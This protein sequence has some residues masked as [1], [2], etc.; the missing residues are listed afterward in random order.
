MNK[1]LLI[2][3]KELLRVFGDRKLVMGLFVTPMLTMVVVY[4]FLGIF[5]GGMATKTAE[6]QCNV[7]V[8]G[9]APAALTARLEQNECTLTTAAPEEYDALTQ[10]IREEDKVDMLLVFPDGFEEAI[11]RG[12][13][14][15]IEVVCDPSI[16]GSKKA[17]D[18]FTAASGEYRDELLA[19]RL[20]G[21]EKLQLFVPVLNSLEN[22]EETAGRMIGSFVVMF[23]VIFIFSSSMQQGI[24][25]IAGEKERGVFATLLMAPVSRTSIAAGKAISL[26]IVAVLASFSI[27]IGILLSILVIALYF[28]IR[29][30]GMDAV[31]GQ[32]GGALSGLSSFNMFSVS[33]MLTLLLQMVMIGILSAAVICF[34]SSFTKTVKEAGSKIT[35]IYLLVMLLCYVPLMNMGATAES[36]LLYLIPLYGNINAII[37]LMAG[38]LTTIPLVLSVF[39]ALGCSALLIF[40]TGRVFQKEKYLF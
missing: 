33:A 21:A 26:T 30:G 22:E 13:A 1:F 10:R 29:M 12:E 8:I 31:M 24:D 35:P 32:V 15:E 2:L 7:S 4:G 18:I 6:H 25:I 36:S 5:I 34:V 27:F 17:Y 16:D 11:A 20:G 14:P 38:T 19:E 37:S 40:L 39:S 3:K 28:V 23:I 9:E